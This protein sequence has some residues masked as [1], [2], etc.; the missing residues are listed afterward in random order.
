MFGSLNAGQLELFHLNFSKIMLLP[1]VNEEE[2]I[3]QCKP[4]YLLNFSFKI[5]TEV[6]T[7]RLSTVADHVVRPSQTAFMQGRDILDGVVILH[8][9][10]HELHKKI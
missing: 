6:A 9:A 5:F 2:R 7:I 3:Q 8:E 10:V 1:K 4:I